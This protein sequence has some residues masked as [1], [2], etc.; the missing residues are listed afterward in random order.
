MASYDIAVI[1]GDGV[2]NEIAR[3]AV[4]ILNA[5][6]EK[7]GFGIKTKDFEWGCDYYLKNGKMNPE[8]MLDTL[9]DFDVPSDDEKLAPLVELA[10]ADSQISYNA[11]YIEEDD[12]LKLYL[13]AI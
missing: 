2:G 5:A 1:P 9:K 6:A 13:E 11:K 12:I 10:A 4:K 8:N 3:E 7:Y